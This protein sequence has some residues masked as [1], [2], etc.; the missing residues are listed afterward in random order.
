MPISN[1]APQEK[2]GIIYLDYINSTSATVTST[3]ERI[4]VDNTYR[5]GINILNTGVLPVYIDLKVV[6]TANTYWIKLDPGAFYESP[7]SFNFI[8]EIYAMTIG[9]GTA[10]L[11]IREFVSD[12][13]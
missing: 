4:L 7:S 6:P 9:G 5:I 8:G 12:P 1:P 3:A 13:G 11:Q 2:N 10:I